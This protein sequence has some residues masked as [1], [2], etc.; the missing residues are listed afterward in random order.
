MEGQCR[1]EHHHFTLERKNKNND[2]LVGISNSK[3]QEFGILKSKMTIF[4]IGGVFLIQRFKTGNAKRQM[5]SPLSCCDMLIS[6][7][8]QIATQQSLLWWC[9]TGRLL[10]RRAT[11]KLFVVQGKDRE[12]TYRLCHT[13]SSLNLGKIDLLPI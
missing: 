8:S 12:I 13:E 4:R 7:G 11:G 3:K 2:F 10:G 6:C 9:G 1:K 5:E